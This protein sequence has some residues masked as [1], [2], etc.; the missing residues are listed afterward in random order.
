MIVVVIFTGKPNNSD[1]S[2]EKSVTAL[3]INHFYKSSIAYYLCLENT[4]DYK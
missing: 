2:F 4:S 1:E 3:F